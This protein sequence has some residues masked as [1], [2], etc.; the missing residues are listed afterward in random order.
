[1]AIQIADELDALE[2]VHRLDVMFQIFQC[3]TFT[4]DH[5]EHIRDFVSYPTQDLQQEADVFLKGNAPQEKQYGPFFCDAV[6]LTKSDPVARH[7]TGRLDAGRDDFC[8]RGDAIALEHMQ[9]RVRGHDHA[10]QTISLMA[11]E[12]LGDQAHQFLR[13]KR[14]IVVEILFKKGVVGFYAGDA[15]QFR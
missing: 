11:R 7:E 1:M 6:L 4:G 8:R 9:H 12:T 14:D 15:Q 10:I 2:Q 3:G 13:N 5:E